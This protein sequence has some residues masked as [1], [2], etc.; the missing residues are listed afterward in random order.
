MSI[1]FYSEEEEEEKEESINKYKDIFENYENNLPTLPEALDQM[2][3]SAKIDDK[4]SNELTKDILN[5]CKKEIDKKYDEINKKYNRIS[6]DDAY[7]ICSYTC[8]SK[9]KQYSP[10]RL[11]NQNLVSD[12]R[13]N[14]IEN[15]SKYLYIFLK[16]LRKLPRYYPEKPNKYLFRCLTC[17]VKITKDPFNDKFIPYIVGN[18]KTFWGFTSTS[19][20][21]K[22]TYNFLKK[23]KF[24]NKKRK[25]E[26]KAGTLFSLGGD[27][28]GYDITLFNYYK[29]NEILLEPERKFIVDNV[30]PSLNKIINITCTILKT[31]LI[32]HNNAPQLEE[33]KIINNNI[34]NEDN[35]DISKYIIKI[36][37]E[38]KK[39]DNN[40]KYDFISGIGLLCYI[41]QKNIKALITYNHIINLDFLNKEK[42]LIII[43]NGKYKEINL[44]LDRFKYSYENIDITIIEIIEEDNIYNFIELEKYINSRNYVNEEIISVY[45]KNN[46]SIEKL[47]CKIKEKKD[48]YYIS[49]IE[50]IKEGII[51]L[52]D[53][54]KLLGLIVT[55]NKEKE[56]EI[57]PM[58]IILN[59]I[60]FI[61]YKYDIKKD[62]LGKE[63]QL[64]NSI[65]YYREF[66]NKEI[67]N[68][69]K[70]IINGELQITILKYIFNKEGIYI[71]YLIY[72]NQINNLSCLFRNCPS[73]KEIDLSS[74]NTNQVINMS[75]MFN[76]CSN[77]EK[78]NLS[79]FN[80]SQVI[81]MSCMFNNCSSLKKVNLSS[82][83]TKK[84]TNMSEMFSH[85]SSLKEL[86]L[87]SFDT[88]QVTN[89]SY[90]FTG[91]SSLEQINLSSFRTDKVTNISHIFSDCKSLKEI[92]SS[93][94][95]IKKV[96][97]LACIFKNCSSLVEIN[98]SS[99][100][101]R[102]VTN[103]SEIFSYC[104]GLKKL[105]LTSFN[106]NKVT[107]LSSM[108]NACSSLKE[109]NISSF[110][111]NQVTDSSSMFK[112]CSSL[113]EIDLSSIK[114][115]QIINMSSMFH[116]CS[117][118]KKINLSTFNTNQVTNMSNMFSNCSSLK[119]I[120]LSTFNTN[121]VTNMS[122]MFNG[123]SS[124]EILNIS[125]FNTNQVIDMSSMFY[126]CSS[127]KELDLSFFNTNK[128]INMSCMFTGCS[129]LKKLNLISFDINNVNNISYMFCDCSSLKKLNIS[130]FKTNQVINVSGMFHNCFSLKKIKCNDK[131][132]LEQFEKEKNCIII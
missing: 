108:F 126:H 70:A 87:L 114:T 15:I 52:K 43:I 90:M 63:I 111:T 69:I 125:T 118:L 37:M 58:N 77:I 105:D 84:V 83:I 1:I 112:G 59:Q 18:K 80:T 99:F 68:K 27:I 96:T 119:E 128:V 28:W 24:T 124:L 103:M 115:N 85:C 34:E 54:Y 21:P 48:E 19:P 101:T 9:E 45:L 61:K 91:C 132:I 11:L 3:K 51:I 42:N 26:I 109:L 53:N 57:I 25:E 20:N 31:P 56:I 8:E 10:Y 81:D 30:L 106:T 86:I 82:F 117:S 39:D 29:E 65:F 13:K 98:I 14:G 73:L 104:S 74:F 47:N 50:S 4:K 94:F 41:R 55:N 113:E 89:M 38:I 35:K 116:D 71:I 92:N 120:N 2:F 44:K 33:D 62:D 64:I 102:Q 76:N 46:K 7:I 72:L 88:N 49:N 129:S 17:E 22:T 93:S 107:N 110:D 75:H 5:K 121:Q 36:E 78:I 131:K 23:E 6:K 60:N 130:S 67:E 127:L 100:D 79:S 40:G 122:E 97:S 66:N 16:S 95:N 12:N 123:C 32:L